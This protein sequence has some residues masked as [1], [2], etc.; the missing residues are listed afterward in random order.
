M[1]TLPLQDLLPTDED[2]AAY[3]RDGFHVAHDVIPAELLDTAERGMQ[4]F[5]AG[6]HDAPFPGTTP[7][8]H[9]DWKPEHGNTIRK[10]DY[11]SIQVREL[12]ALTRS[13]VIGAIA[14]KLAGANQIR[15][16]HDQLLYKPA[17]LDSAAGNVGWHTDRQYWQTCTSEAMLTGWGPVPRLR[18]HRRRRHL[19]QGQPPVGAG[20]AG[21]LEHRPGRPGGPVRLAGPAGGEGHA[22]AAARLDD[23]PPLQDDPRKRPE[24]QR[25]ATAVGRHPPAAR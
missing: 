18:R 1:T 21:L 25:S 24:P 15:L 12:A 4:R 10:N 6:D 19:R 5:Y 2:V 22:G 11:T 13:P 8:D 9:Y 23:L 20:P 17:G 16:W 14:A 7:Y 3:R